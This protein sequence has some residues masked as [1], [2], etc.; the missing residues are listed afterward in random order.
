MLPLALAAAV[1]AASSEPAP[2]E[3]P[4]SLAVDGTV[5]GAA[6]LV[7]VGSEIFKKDLAPA[8]CKWCDPPA[9]DSSIRDA[10]RW[11]T[12][13]AAGTASNVLAFGGMEVLTL[14]ASNVASGGD[15]RA[16]GADAL[17]IAEA[18]TLAAVAN[19]ATKFLSISSRTSGS[20]VLNCKG[21][22]KT[23]S[24]RYFLHSLSCFLMN[25]R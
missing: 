19:Q 4:Y 6:A 17:I 5:A 24:R 20:N 15:W 25:R 9:F 8:T 12:P 21:S 16:T 10:L 1:A 7:W 3:L 2:R 14:A 13:G 11:S 18:A 23:C 22:L